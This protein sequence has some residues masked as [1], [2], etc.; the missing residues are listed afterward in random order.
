MEEAVD[1]EF[2]NKTLLKDLIEELGKST[3]AFKISVLN[4]EVFIS[5]DNYMYSFIR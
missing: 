2:A 1:R 3:S 4:D 5:V